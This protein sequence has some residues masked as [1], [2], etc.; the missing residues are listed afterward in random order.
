[1]RSTCLKL[2][3]AWFNARVFFGLAILAIQAV[4]PQLEPSKSASALANAG[5][6]RIQFATRLYDFDKI[7]GGEVLKYMFVFTNVGNQVLEIKDIQST[8]GCTTS[9]TW[10]RRVEPGKTGSIPIELFTVNYSGRIEKSLTV[11]CNDT[12]QPEVTLRIQGLVWWPVEVVPQSAVLTG[13]LDGPSNRVASVRIINHEEEPLSLAEP[14]SNL[15]AITGELKPI[16]PGQ[17]YELFVKLV[18]PLGSGNVF[19]QITIKTSSKKVPLLKIPAWSIAQELVKAIPAEVM[20]PAVPM[21]N[22]FT[23]N[24]AIRSIWTNALTLAKPAINVKGVQLAIQE[25]KAGRY[26]QVKLTFP[27]GCRIAPSDRPELTVE[28]NH[29]LYPLI[30]VPILQRQ[31]F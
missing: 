16:K 15:R 31:R 6:P 24:I 11:L 29:P 27:P 1:M 9:E 20:L 8:C 14:Q 22:A 12:N 4:T 30:R 21:T 28:S 19:G 10:A 3:P 2:A 17:E 26:Y 23:T 7:I 25:L 18:P 5:G 13:L